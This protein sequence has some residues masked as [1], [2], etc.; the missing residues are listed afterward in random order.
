MVWNDLSLA[1]KETLVRETATSLL[2]LFQLRFSKAGSLYIGPWGEVDVGPIVSVPFFRMIDGEVRFPDSEALDMSQFRGPFDRT[3]EY[4]SSL[5]RAESYVVDHRR[6]SLL[7]ML[8]G[9]EERLALGKRV[10]EKVTRLAEIYP[11]DIAIGLNHLISDAKQ[12]FS[13]MLDDFR[14]ANIMVSINMHLILRD[15]LQILD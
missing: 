11:G 5:A 13:L 7:E 3:C 6:D 4:L 12:P 8:E 14:P 10:L 1:A 2:T 9:G 15:S